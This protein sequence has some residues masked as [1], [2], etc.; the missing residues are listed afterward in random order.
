MK[1]MIMLVRGGG[2]LVRLVW[3]IYCGIVKLVCGGFI[4]GDIVRLFCICGI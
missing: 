1:S 2:V 4:I 3:V